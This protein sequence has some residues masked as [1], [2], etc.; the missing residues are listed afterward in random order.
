MFQI[1]NDR[2]AISEHTLTE[3]W[4]DFRRMHFVSLF[5]DIINY[6]T[7]YSAVKAS[8]QLQFLTLL[9]AFCPYLVSFRFPG[10]WYDWGDLEDLSEEIL[11]HIQ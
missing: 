3:G 2:L 10:V 6:R 8:W 11:W 5:R 4:M 1:Y 9:A 7:E